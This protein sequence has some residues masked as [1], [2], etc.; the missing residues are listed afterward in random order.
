MAKKAT[1][2]GENG[3]CCLSCRRAVCRLVVVAAAAVMRTCYLLRDRH[4]MNRNRY[5]CFNEEFVELL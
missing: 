5:F 2:G 3:E 1:A 4:D